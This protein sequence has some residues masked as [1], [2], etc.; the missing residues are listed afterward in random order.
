MTLKIFIKNKFSD[1]FWFYNHIGKKIFFSI[2]LAILVG[3]LDGVGL[4]MFLPLLQIVNESQSY[5]ASGLGNL[6][7]ILNWITFIGFELNLVTTLFLMIVFFVLKGM[8]KYI[9]EIFRIILQQNLL[10]KARLS[11]LEDFNSI[12]FDFYLK[13]DVGQIQNTLTGEVDRIQQAFNFYF[14]TL[15][16]IFL[17]LVYIIFAF[18]VDF[19]FAFLVTL[20]GLSTNF[21]YKAIYSKTKRASSKFTDSSNFLQSQILQHVHNFKY[22]HATGTYKTYSNKIKSTILNIEVTRRSIGFFNSILVAAR[23]PIVI[24]VVGIVIYIH[25][26]VLNGV[27]SSILISLLFFYRALTS[28]T[29]LQNNWN[30]YISLSGSMANMK[31]FSN[32][33]KKNK[34]I[35]F[36]KD[37]KG[38][39]KRI[40]ISKLNFS[41][42]NNLIL[43]KIDLVINKNECIALVGES[44]SGKTSLINVITGLLAYQTGSLKIDGEE[45]SKINKTAFQTKIGYITQEPVIFNDTL[46]NNITLWDKRNEKNIA[47]FNHV[48]NQSVLEGLICQLPNREETMLGNN[49]VNLSGGQRQRISIARE[50]YKNKDILILDEAT[51]SLDL[52]TEKLIKKTIDSLKNSCTIIIIAHRLSTIKNVDKIYRLE[53]GILKQETKT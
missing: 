41:Y 4:T 29:T 42:G 25:V 53:N 39:K 45:L 13:S 43:K 10:K 23:E 44:G 34:Q 48:I 20:G 15:E 24:L 21:F 36:Q 28:L 1:F 19:K 27:L 22:L 17:V 5:N 33:L 35:E 46:F 26:N 38:F 50:L 8:V 49:G 3:L 51:S 37:Y 47:R 40:E 32:K 52:H 14:R 11:L 2:I 30:R 16:Q 9:S 31:L 12:S 7:I 6:E 18:F